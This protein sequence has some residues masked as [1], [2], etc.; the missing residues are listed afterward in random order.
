M[1]T[2]LPSVS[3]VMPV[4]NEERHLGAAVRRGILDQDY[5]GIS[6]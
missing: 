1:T 6:R 4:V 5:Q 3:V 2:P